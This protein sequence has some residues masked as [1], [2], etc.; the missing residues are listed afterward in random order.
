MSQP[1]TFEHYEILKNEDGSFV[2]LGHGAMGVTYQAFDTN[3]RC[4]V[5]L[6]VISASYLNDPTATE[7]FLR[8]ARGAARLRHRNI[9]SV[10]HL[11]RCGDSYFYSMEYIEGETVDALVKREGPMDILLA[12]DVASQV[13]AALVAAEKQGLVHRDIKPS[14][15]MF[16]REDDGEAVVKVIDFGL[17]KAAQLSTT[18]GALT[19]SGF[20][21]TPYFASPEQLDQGREDI[22]SDIYSLGITLWFMLTGKPT[23]M[24]SIASVI[25]QHLDKAPAFESLA[26]L[27]SSVVVVLQRMLEKDLDKRIQ[28]PVELRAELKH[29]IEIL[30]SSRRAAAPPV[31]TLTYDANFETMVLNSAHGLEENV[32][33]GA[34]LSERYRLIED[35]NPANPHRSFH[36]EDIVL[37]RRVR[38]KIVRAS[39]A[40]LDLILE[41]C[42]RLK[43]IS[44]PHFI[45]VLAAGR[46]NDFGFIV[47]EWID[48]LPLLDLLR[49][50]RE[51]TLR[52]TL[53]LL[54]QIAPAVDAAREFRVQLELH[55]RDI[56]VHFP[57]G[58]Q[59]P[60]APVILRCPVAEWPAFIVKTNSLGHFEDDDCAATLVDTRKPGDTAAGAAED[61]VRL[62]ALAYELLGGKA[63]SV[64][65]LASVSEEGNAV[66]R[67]CLNPGTTFPTA[68]EFVTA[69][70]SVSPADLVR[71]GLATSVPVPSPEKPAPMRTADAGKSAAGARLAPEPV[72][73]QTTAKSPLPLFAAA[74]IALC[75]L[76]AGVWWMTKSPPATAPASLPAGPGAPAKNP[77]P[78]LAARPP[79]QPGQPWKNSLEMTF[80]P[81]RDLHLAAV[82]TRVRDFE[83]FVKATGYDAAG[84]MYSAQRDGFKQHQHTWRNP[85]FSQTPENPVVGV[86]WEDANNFC[87]WL[88]K[89]ERSEGA[90]AAYQSYR[91]PTD[92]EWSEA[93]GLPAEDGATPEERSGRIKGVY[94][95]GRPFPPVGERWNYSGAETRADLAETWAV[96]PNYHD[97]FP[98]T[99]PAPTG[100]GLADLGG[101]VW[102]W[103]AD[104]YNK[105][106]R[107]RVLR[108]G[109]WATSRPEE[110]LSSYRRGFDPSFRH[111]DIGFRCVIASGDG[112]R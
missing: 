24:G 36:G 46:T 89:K 2:E 82:E 70:S 96:I 47:L 109:S 88:T 12:L 55:L 37:K 80:E 104:L 87:A 101:N 20:V 6:K 110:M 81:L 112:T 44:H 50:R 29:C 79:L 97:A 85:G 3:L 48:G 106:S 40:E 19:S 22:R 60:S 7:R 14:N 58:F 21:G 9:A 83:A 17:V 23:F 102:E 31:Q 105:T 78:P 28:T 111:D 53:T 56:F 86:S 69:L 33:I 10:F 4:T 71:P 8:E 84:G 90:L 95:W 94:P 18:A 32:W 99:R 73:I 65:P 75:A 39:P 93:A 74:G 11:G 38:V 26:V 91:L 92:R 51:L 1:E 43:T 64:A 76:L 62:G 35:L 61:V 57:E 45:E 52:E 34:L 5:A 107:W 77:A 49:A 108:G 98:R 30:Q 100:A 42:D 67:R 68:R 72:P 15:L 27:P 13:A 25:A 63:G 66:L 16:L 41:E 103:C 59:E 54:D